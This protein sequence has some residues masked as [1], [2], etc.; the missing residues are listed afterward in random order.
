MDSLPF[1]IGATPPLVVVLLMA[2]AMFIDTTPILGL[3]LPGDILVVAV[4]AGSDPTDAVLAGIG[5]VAGTLVSWTLFFFVGRRVGPSLR[6]GRV[7]RW[8]GPR[9]DTAEQLL[10]GRGARALMLV[11]FLPV[12]NAVVPMIAGVLGLSYRQFLRFA[13]IAAV[14]WVLVFGAVGVWAGMASD[15]VLGGSPLGVLIFGAPGFAAGWAILLYLRRN[16][17][18]SQPP[19]TGTRDDLRVAG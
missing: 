2:V 3:L 8:I 14:L 19:P 9:W 10:T 13:V 18:K 7:G 15:A 12:L 17:A 11:Q 1:Q 4:F 6:R 5:V 16:L